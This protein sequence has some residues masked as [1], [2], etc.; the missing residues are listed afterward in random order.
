MT[1]IITSEDVARQAGVSTATVDRVMNGRAGVRPAT[2]ERVLQAVEMLGY[3]RDTRASS[4]SRRNKRKIWVFL[5]DSNTSFRAALSEEIEAAAMEFARSCDLV[6]VQAYMAFEPEDLVRSLKSVERDSCDGVI[7]VATDDDDVRSSINR[8]SDMGIPVVTLVSDSPRAGRAHY[9]GIDNIAAG[10]TA[11]RLMGRFLIDDRRPVALV[12]GSFLVRDHVERR[13]GFE[14]LM[15][16]DFP[17]V[18]ILPALEG[19]DDPAKMEQVVGALLQA[20]PDLGGLY[21]IGAGNRGAI[22]AFANT[23]RG[24]VVFITH[25]LTDL[26]REAIRNGI[27]DAVIHQDPG[28][29][30]RSAF[31]LLQAE[32]DGTPIRWEQERIR[33]EIFVKDNLP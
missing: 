14:Q 25:E 20:H 32:L 11:G 13:L 22:Q 12:C 16:K 2:A 33:I 10:R 5:P 23:G 8:I 4:L 19:F 7:L 15:H 3:V 9:V 21:S 17:Q 29:E 1:R 30:V 24:D 27:I 26:S 31:R 18:P 6:D 28:H